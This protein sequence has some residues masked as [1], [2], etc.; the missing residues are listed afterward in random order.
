[1]VDFFISPFLSAKL[2]TWLVRKYGHHSM[3]KLTIECEVLILS[4]RSEM[5]CV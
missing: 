1:M 3:M 5:S 2:A 4:R